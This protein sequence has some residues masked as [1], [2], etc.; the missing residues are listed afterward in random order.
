MAIQRETSHLARLA[1]RQ[2]LG[3]DLGLALDSV[4]E[5]ESRQYQEP[6]PAS[7]P[8]QGPAPAKVNQERSEKEKEEK[9]PNSWSMGSRASAR[10]APSRQSRTSR[11]M[12]CRPGSTCCR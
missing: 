8:H 2:D 5:L 1:L 4:P 11:P 7:I 9:A 6:A 12:T 3:Q 10:A